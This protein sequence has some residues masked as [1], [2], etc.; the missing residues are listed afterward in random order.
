MSMRPFIYAGDLARDLGFRGM[1]PSFR[2]WCRE[3]GLEARDPHKPFAFDPDDVRE[4]L[5]R[6]PT[7]PP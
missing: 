5:S 6:A 4:A 7:S 1:V 2:R 3:R